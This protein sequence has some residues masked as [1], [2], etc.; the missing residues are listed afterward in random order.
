[1][2]R[3]DQQSLSDAARTFGLR[4][5]VL[6]GSRAK[7]RPEPGPESDVDIAIHG[8]PRERYWDCYKAINEAIGEG[9]VDLVRLEDADALFR[10]EI[11]R[12]GVLLD[13]DPDFFCEFRAYAYK[14]FVDSADLFTLEETLFRKKMQRLGELLDD[15]TR[16]RSA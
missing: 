13:G 1:M 3:I 10:D 16:V 6:F 8:C 14:D 12:F 9:E 7:G 4:L 11:M 2:L 15:S 5:V